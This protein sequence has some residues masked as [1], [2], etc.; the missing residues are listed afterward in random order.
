MALEMRA[1]SFPKLGVYRLDYTHRYGRPSRRLG[2]L[3]LGLDQRNCDIKEN[4]S[5]DIADVKMYRMQQST[6]GPKLGFNTLYIE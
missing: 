3:N 6:I 1:A 4:P 2:P 5:V